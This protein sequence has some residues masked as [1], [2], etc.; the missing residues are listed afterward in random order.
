METHR[1]LPMLPMSIVF[2]RPHSYEALWLVLK[3]LQTSLTHPVKTDRR[4]LPRWSRGRGGYRRERVLMT[5][6]Q[7]LRGRTELRE[8]RG[9]EVKDRP[10]GILCSV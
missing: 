6:R 1:S 8:G 5:K 4:G 3:A 9:S 2:H 7:I 10:R